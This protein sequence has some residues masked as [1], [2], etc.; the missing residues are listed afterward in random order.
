RPPAA[1]HVC[2][3][4]YQITFERISSEH[5]LDA[6]LHVAARPRGR[7]RAEVAGCQ[8]RARAAKVRMIQ[9]VEQVALHPYLQAPGNRERLAERN[10]PKEHGRS[11]LVSWP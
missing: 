10:I 2:A 6:E 9:Q 11:R 8:I 1:T 4:P 3:Y 7:N 5:Q